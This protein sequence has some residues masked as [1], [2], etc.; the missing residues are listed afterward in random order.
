MFYLGYFIGLFSGFGF[1]FLGWAAI[2]GLRDWVN[3]KIKLGI[4]EGC[5]NGRKR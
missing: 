2:D 1:V 3:K 5:K 4:E